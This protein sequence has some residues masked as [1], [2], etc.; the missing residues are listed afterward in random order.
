M[1]GEVIALPGGRFAVPGNRWD[2]VPDASVD[3]PT[4][5]VIVPY[6]EQ[7]QQLSMLLRALEAQTHPLDRLQV[8]IADDGSP[9]RPCVVAALDV[10]VVRQDDRGFRAAAARN[11]GARAARGDVLCFLDA[12]TVPEPDYVERI[13][14]LPSLVP[15]AVTVGRRR[16]A[17]LTGP[18]PQILPE[19][20]WL[21]DAYRD[22]RDLLD[23]DWRSYR[24]V[25]SA[26][27]CCTRALFEE[28]G[29]FD[30]SFVQYGGEDWELA[31][32]AYLAGAVLAHVPDAVAW[33]DGPDWA[34]RSD[35]DQRAAKNAEAL[36]MAR[37][38]TDPFARTHGVRYAVPDLV[39]HVHTAGHTPASLLVTLGSILGYGDVAVWID[40][41]DAAETVAALGIEDSRVH[42]GTPESVSRSRFGVE[43]TGR[44][45]FADGALR[46]LGNR[47]GPAGVGRIDVRWPSG[48][49]VIFRSWRAVRR[50]ARWAPG[51]GE[52]EAAVLERLFGVEVLAPQDAGASLLEEQPNLA[53]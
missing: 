46:E 40:G 14:R 27:M 20:Q 22:S 53:W 19:P 16:H 4:V 45:V 21:L 10:T 8:V 9:H 41:V 36:A 30:E 26:V 39:A 49:S 7:P 29:G 31:N 2:L 12:D 42:V 51:L 43:V 24:H 44:V 5:T 37:L 47:T 35:A 23:A 48:E 15:D 1:T 28:I 17:D 13:T 18:E 34:G 11:L 50:A 32:R 33:H 52:P 25:I 38:V 6:Y 3:P